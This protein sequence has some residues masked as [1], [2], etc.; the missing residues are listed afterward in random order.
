M[1]LLTRFL[2][3]RWRREVAPAS[4]APAPLLLWRADLPGF[5][6]VSENTLAVLSAQ[7]VP[8]LHRLELFDADGQRRQVVER[9]SRRPYVVLTPEAGAPALG[10]VQVSLVLEAERLGAEAAALLR[11]LPAAGRACC[12]LRRRP[13]DPWLALQP[14]G[15]ASLEL[16]AEPPPRL[17]VLNPAPS[18]VALRIEA[19]GDAG[20]LKLPPLWLPPR[21]V[22]AVA[23]PAGARRLRLE[24]PGAPAAP[25]VVV[26]P[27]DGA[28]A[29]VV[30]QV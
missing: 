24:A 1:T 6:Y 10:T 8:A 27:A 13:D 25:Q 7:S 15:E 5:R 2:P 23:V 4:A 21:G 30:L 28:A 29:C 16:G 19:S 17:L 22:R 3:A 14:G 11:Q 18:R 9:R 12:Q 26:E 20:R